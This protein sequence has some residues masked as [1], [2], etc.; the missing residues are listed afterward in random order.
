[1]RQL[2]R[3][4][5]EDVGG[6]GS[7][8]PLRVRGRHGLEAARPW[9]VGLLMVA[10]VCGAVWPF[11]RRH[12]QAVAVLRLMSGQHVPWGVGMVAAKAIRSDEVRFSTE[13]GLVRARL[14][15]PVGHPDA[16]AL[17]VLHGV[18]YRGIDEPRLV[19]FAAAMAGCG[20]RVL[21]PE[22]PGIKDYHVDA[23]ASG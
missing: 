11:V 12:L 4:V 17:M 6:T 16:P 21:T 8:A 19:S 2:V 23:W 22:L 3:L 18:H 9:L 14:Y 7:T 10:V 1:M 13:A 20:L 15:V 5:K